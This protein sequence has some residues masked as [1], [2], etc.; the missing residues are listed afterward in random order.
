M[1]DFFNQLGRTIGGF[2]TSRKFWSLAIGLFLD[3]RCKVR[4]IDMPDGLFTG[5]GATFSIGTAAEDFAKHL[6]GKT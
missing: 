1:K 6:K 4:G 5:A 3:Y 2:L